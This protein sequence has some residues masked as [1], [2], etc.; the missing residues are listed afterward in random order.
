LSVKLTASSGADANFIATEIE[1]SLSQTKTRGGSQGNSS[2]FELA[3]AC[4]TN[5]NATAYDV[6]AFW[7]WEYRVPVVLG[8][9]GN[10]TAK[11]TTCRVTCTQDDRRPNHWPGSPEDKAAC[12]KK[13]LQ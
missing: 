6:Y 11:M 9:G 12:F 2:V 8:T 1:G 10:T 5:I 7:Q 3:M 4:N 13:R